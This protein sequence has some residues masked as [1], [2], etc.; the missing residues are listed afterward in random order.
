MLN[1]SSRSW[2]R[3]FGA[4]RSARVIA[5]NFNEAHSICTNGQPFSKLRSAVTQMVK[6]V[7]PWRCDLHKRSRETLPSGEPFVSNEDENAEFVVWMWNVRNKPKTR[8]Q[9]QNSETKNRK[10]Q[11]SFITESRKKTICRRQNQ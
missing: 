1:P 3:R 8:G 7:V 5:W 6:K 11:N 9:T 2:F 10:R 4:F